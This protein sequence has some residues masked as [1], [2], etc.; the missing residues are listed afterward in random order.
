MLDINDNVQPIDSGIDPRDLRN[1]ND[2]AKALEEIE[3]KQ[4]RVHISEFLIYQKLFDK[5]QVENHDKMEIRLLST[6][7]IRRFNPYR[8]IEI[9]NDNDKLLFRIPQLFVPIKDVSNEYTELVDKFRSDGPSDI[10]KY[11]IEATQGLLAAIIKSQVDVSAEGYDT[12][13]DYIKALAT[14]YQKDIKAFDDMKNGVALE[15]TPQEKTV[16]I[17]SKSDTIDIDNME[18]LQWE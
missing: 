2:L 6:R 9:Y 11:S 13:G 16:D 17:S 8:P 15:T 18:G 1:I 14:E 4:N 5:E 3:S 10:P 7:F 12:Y